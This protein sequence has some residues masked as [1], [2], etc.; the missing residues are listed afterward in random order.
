MDIE[1]LQR[2]NSAYVGDYPFLQD[3]GSEWAQSRPL[4]GLRILHNIPLTR[5][6]MLKLEPLYLGGA[7]VT[8]THL[9]LPGL[10]PKED[11]VD[12]LRDAGATVELDHRRI[13]GTFDIALDCCAQ[14]PAM[15]NVNIERGYVELTQSGTPIYSELETDLPVYSLDLSKLKCLEGMF[16]TGEAC[17][18]AIKQFVTPDLDGRK[19]VLFGYGKVGRGIAR[20]LARENVRLTV[21]DINATY[22]DQAAAAGHKTLK[23]ARCQELLETINDAFAVIFATGHPGL[24]QSLYAPSEIADNV[25]LIN[26]GADDEFGDDYPANRIVADKAP[27]NFLLDSP[28]TM[29][30]IDP[31]F[32]AHNRCCQNILS[33][34]AHGFTALPAELDLPFVDAWSRR[35]GIDVSDIY[36]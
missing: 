7:D 10:E 27:L 4:A 34:D 21:V 2:F 30:F 32:A 6:T 5:E 36:Y 26:M 3:L 18:R 33:D 24:L 11:C 14:V 12:L 13:N 35:Y 15:E 31:I 9:E 20:Y 17:V 8:V 25:Q 28:T 29:F 1:K 19:I 22:L 23:S 16:G